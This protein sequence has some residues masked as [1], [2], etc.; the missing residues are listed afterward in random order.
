IEAKAKTFGRVILAHM[1]TQLRPPV[2]YTSDN[3]SAIGTAGH[4]EFLMEETTEGTKINYTYDVEIYNLFLRIFGG[5][6]IGWYA[7][8]F[9]EHA[10]ID[11]LKEMLEK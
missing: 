2:W 3:K 10:V 6:F 7:M 8:R 4:E 9:W 5:V 1:E 11:K